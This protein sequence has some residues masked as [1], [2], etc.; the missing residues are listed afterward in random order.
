MRQQ[1][2][3]NYLITNIQIIS[4]LLNNEPRCQ[5]LEVRKDKYT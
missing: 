1:L 4:N 2:G 3:D 5:I